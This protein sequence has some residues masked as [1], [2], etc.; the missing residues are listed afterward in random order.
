MS[1]IY[2]GYECSYAT[3]PYSQ[4]TW[5]LLYIYANCK[6]DNI[7]GKTHLDNSFSDRSVDPAPVELDSNQALSQVLGST[8][9]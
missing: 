9:F 6:T 3:G 5:S 2:K 7:V 1:L 8:E 4:I